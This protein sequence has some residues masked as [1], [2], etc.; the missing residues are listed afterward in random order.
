MDLSPQ[1][2]SLTIDSKA[3]TLAASDSAVA[4]NEYL[5]LMEDT[6]SPRT[7]HVW[8][9]IAAVAALIGKN[10]KFQSGPAYTVH[11]NLFVVLLG[12]AGLRKSSAIN[13]ITRLLET[14]SINF[15]PTDTGGQRQG[16]MTAL[17]GRVARHKTVLEMIDGLDG[18]PLIP[19]QLKPRLSSD[20]ALWAPE[21]GRLFGS[22]S[23]EM[24]DFLVSLWDGEDIDY[25][26]R[27]G[28]VK[29]RHPLATMLGATTPSS[30]ASLLPE[31]APGHGILSRILFI[32]DEKIY[33][34]V[35]LP[36]EPNENWWEL[37]ARIV[38]RFEWIDWNRED[39]SL[40][41][42]ARGCYVEHYGYRP[43]LEDPRLESYRERRATTLIKVSM[44]LAALR[45]DTMINEAD[46][47]LAHELLTLA[48]PSMHRALEFFGQNRIYIGRMLMIQFLKNMGSRGR[49]NASE[50]KAAAASSLN[51]REAEEALK[52]MLASGELVQFRDQIMLGSAMKELDA[53]KKLA[54][55]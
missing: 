11:A 35:P 31:N 5:E 1:H 15:G 46:I 10:A 24:A 27:S 14:T 16:L 50:L 32:H 39:F 13:H 4:L 8:S 34:R 36:P 33:K 26:T 55:D 12:P 37:R 40:S 20:L 19:A 45:Q 9:L 6:E 3:A 25:Q 2:A 18:A 43:Q 51:E 44:C 17:G 41:T 22:G 29:I 42:A 52:S 54:R 30:L 48:E 38:K 47:L 28:I 49:S 53:A 23:R 21:L 7:F